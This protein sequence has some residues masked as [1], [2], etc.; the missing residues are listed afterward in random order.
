MILM[1]ANRDMRI[2][3]DCRSNKICEYY[4]IGKFSS[5]AA[6]L[7]NYRTI[8]CVGGLHYGKHLFHIVYIE[9]WY[10][11]IF[12]CRMVE[13]LAKSYQWHFEAFEFE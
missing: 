12:L 10:S 2:Q 3:F 7:H 4:I 1:H 9:C 11:V 5:S 13:K 8:C 6:G